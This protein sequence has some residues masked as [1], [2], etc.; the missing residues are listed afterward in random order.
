MFTAAKSIPYIPITQ[1]SGVSRRIKL[2]NGAANVDILN[3]YVSG[4]AKVAIMLPN[5]IISEKVFTIVS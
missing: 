1:T 2:V 5:S 4:A 3:V